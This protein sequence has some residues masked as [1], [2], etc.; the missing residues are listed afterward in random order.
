MLDAFVERMAATPFVDGSSDC[1]LT[2]A[3]WV[4]VATGCPDPAADLRGRY[5]TALGRERLLKRRFGLHAVMA[6]CAIKAGLRPTTN[7]VRGDVGTIRHGRQ[8]LAAICL[9]ERWAV[10]SSRGIDA[11]N[12]DEIIFAW[13]VPHG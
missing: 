5:T 8:A 3:D 13:R 6:G 7:P 9:G 10:K 12:P 11:L 2:V 1:A 4:M